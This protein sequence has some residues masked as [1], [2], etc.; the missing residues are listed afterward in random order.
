MGELKKD[1]RG[2]IYVEFLIA[3]TPIFFMFLAM[4]QMA[5]LYASHLVV[6]HAAVTA[7]RAAIVVLDD[8]PKHYGGASRGA[9]TED[10]ECN[11]GMLDYLDSLLSLLG[12]APSTSEGDPRFVYCNGGPRLHAIR[13]AAAMPLL[14]VSPSLEQFVG[15]ESVYK[16]I[17]GTPAGRAATGAALYNRAAVAVTFPSAPGATEYV[18]SIGRHQNVTVRVTYLFH[19]AVPI[20][21]RFMCDSVPELYTGIPWSDIA[22]LA[23]SVDG[24][25]PQELADQINHI[26]EETDRLESL[27]PSMRELEAAQAPWLMAFAALTG[28]RFKVVRAE[29]TLPNH[30]AD[31]TYVSESE[32]GGGGETA[33]AG[34]GP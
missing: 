7:A 32:G 2:A 5:L 24:A 19:C 29:A 3:F 17:G 15:E 21:N 30:G 4:V 25:S 14:A 33:E 22:D 1:T 31:Y 18:T 20:V 12:M 34:G 8:D 23:T 11:P 27:A 16:A 26:Q 6:Q 10:G 28:A 9:L 13:S